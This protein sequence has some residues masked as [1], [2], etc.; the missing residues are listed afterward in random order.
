MGE[1]KMDT[2]IRVSDDTYKAIIK[3]RGAFEQTF[4]RRLSLDETTFIA[5][6]YV[7]IAYEEYQKLENQHLVKTVIDKDSSVEIRWTELGKIVNAVLPRLMSA[8]GNLKLILDR[9]ALAIRVSQ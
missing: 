6:S 4:A 2:S 9:K 3:A 7:N 5:A 1:R 8:F